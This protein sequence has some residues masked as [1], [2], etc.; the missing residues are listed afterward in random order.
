MD[1]NSQLSLSVFCVSCVRVKWGVRLMSC[2]M[3]SPQTCGECR[4]VAVAFLSPL[5]TAAQPDPCVLAQPFIPLCQLSQC[6]SSRNSLKF[7]LISSV[8]L[9]IQAQIEHGETP[10]TIFHYYFH[11]PPYQPTHPAW[12]PA[13]QCSVFCF[14]LSKFQHEP[15]SPSWT[16]STLRSGW[17]RMP[18]PPTHTHTS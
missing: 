11:R 8:S 13:L 16:V 14:Y 12:A 15:L 5:S 4:L 7:N 6:V 3:M 2:L 17:C 18:P 1:L 10:P 9:P